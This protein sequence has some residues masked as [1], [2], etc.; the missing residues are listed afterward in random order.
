MKRCNFYELYYSANRSYVLYTQ[1][2]KYN[3]GTIS[4]PILML[5]VLN[6]LTKI[7]QIFE[8]SFKNEL[9]NFLGELLPVK[10]RGKLGGLMISIAYICMFVAL[11]LW[12]IYLEQFGALVRKQIFNIF[13]IW[14][15][16]SPLINF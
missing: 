2:Y 16:D 4:G 5:R 1:T 14:F 13:L 11:K 9:L 12:P 6:S 15:F 8:S 3:K 7:L 10:V